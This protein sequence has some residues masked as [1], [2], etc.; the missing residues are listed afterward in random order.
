EN[1]YANRGDYALAHRTLER[2]LQIKPDFI[3]VYI[4]LAGIEGALQHDEASY[5]AMRK[6]MAIARGGRDSDFADIP[7]Q[8]SVLLGEG[9]LANDTGDYQRQI[10]LNREL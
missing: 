1:I 6:A 8:Q 2:A 7:W 5:Q 4:N 9:Q 3:M 10:A